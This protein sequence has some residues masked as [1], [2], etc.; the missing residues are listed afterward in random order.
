M[1]GKGIPLCVSLLS[2]YCL[3]GCAE[4]EWR[5]GMTPS[6][7][8]KG[9]RGNDS[10]NDQGPAEANFRE[11]TVSSPSWPDFRGPKRDG[12]AP[13][14]GMPLDW[15]Q[16]P[17][18]VWR[19]AAGQGHS[20]VIAVA[21]RIYTA[22]QFGEQETLTCRS[23]KNGSLLWQHQEKQ[24]WQDSMGGTGPRST[25]VFSSGKIYFLSSEGKLICLDA[26]S[27]EVAWSRNVLE[28]D[29]EYPHWG[30]A[31]TPLVSDGQVIVSTG[32][33]GGAVKA[34]D[35]SSGKP[36][37]TSELQGQGVYL[38]PSL[39]QLH[40]TS[41]L[42][43]AVEGKLAGID[44]SSGKTLWE[45]AWKIF[46]IKAQ[47][48]Q[49]I[50]MGQDSF[51]LSAGYGKG[52]EVIRLVKNDDGFSTEQV[53]KSKN[54]KTKFSSPVLHTGHVYGFNESSLT[55]LD[56]KTGE[57]KWRGKK[58]GYGRI[59]LA[60]DKLLVLGNTGKFSVIEATPKA[61]K[62]IVSRQIL[63]KERCWNGP[64]LIGGYLVARNGSEISCY[65]WSEK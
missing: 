25:P 53:W 26:V 43:A 39:L 19:Q 31:S 6:L 35:S 14:Q 7:K 9:I 23:L 63:S 15:E 59:L 22:E 41:H 13:E 32:G 52:A 56:G 65:D 20:S 11:Q 17:R 36:R 49:P 28:T 48:A 34:Y 44:P 4:I 45:H 24:T 38:S 46:M 29:Y 18:Q 3:A 62:E 47:I 37:W 27:G 1:K 21:N 8:W 10:F 50:A 2:A 42:L 54:L 64:A 57:L 61:F 5:G 51:L 12:V 33:R 60:N 16:A 58:Y 40:G 30:L 55:C